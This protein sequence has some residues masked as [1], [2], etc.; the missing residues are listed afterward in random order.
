MISTYMGVLLPNCANV[1]YSTSGELSPLLKDP[2]YRAIG[3]GTKIFLGGAEGYIA[4]Q[5]TQH[6]LNHEQLADGEHYYAGGTLAVIGDLKKM[7]S[8][9]IRGC[10][11]NKYGTSLYVGI[12]IPIPV[13]DEE[14]VLSLARTNEQI[15]TKVFDYSVA[16]RK[17]PALRMVSY[18][19]LRSGSI[20]LNGKIVPTAPLSSLVKA[21]K[22]AKVLKERIDN[23]SFTLSE[24]YMKLPK[25]NVSKTLN[26]IEEESV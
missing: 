17:R 16:S 25:D 6:V 8:E 20:E 2:E 10:T 4:W 23:G 9:Y 26:I 19:E 14:M 18:K 21:R 12:G 13:L 24:A 1:T 3:V 22:I 7:D 5:G 11:F 15:F